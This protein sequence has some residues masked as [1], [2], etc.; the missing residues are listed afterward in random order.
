MAQKTI[1]LVEDSLETREL[2]QEVL[3]EA[4]FS[5]T[6]AIDGEDG[7]DKASKGGYDLILLDIM[8]PKMDGLTLLSKLKTNPPKLPNGGILLLTNLE[9][10][11]VIKQALSLGAMDYLVKSNLNPGQIVEKVKSIIK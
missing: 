5:V 11:V 6:P 9:H 3:E 4:G 10:D 7:L 8:M 1:L 2:Y